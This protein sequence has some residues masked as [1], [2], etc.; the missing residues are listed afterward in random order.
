MDKLALIKIDVE[1]FEYQVLKGLKQTL[2][3]HKPR[4]IFEYDSNY[5][6][7]TGQS[8]TEC[9][10]FLQALNYKLYEISPAGCEI[11]NNTANIQSGNLFCIPE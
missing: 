6:I 3:K 5:W 9:C 4:I 2:Q 1:G 10:Q 11:I 8:I 7:N